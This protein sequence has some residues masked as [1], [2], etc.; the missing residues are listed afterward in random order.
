MGLALPTLDT[1]GWVSDVQ[2]KITGI[3]LDYLANNYSQS[4]IH[5]GN[6]RSLPYTIASNPRNIGELR[7]AIERDLEIIYGAYTDSVT[8][9][10]SITDFY[11][12]NELN[13]YNIVI[14]VKVQEGLSLF[15]IGKYIKVENGIIKGISDS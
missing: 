5:L 13:F 14:D 4:D 6:V 12:S 1:N 15:N 8:T 11:E 7:L 10:I 2:S 3:F 9:N